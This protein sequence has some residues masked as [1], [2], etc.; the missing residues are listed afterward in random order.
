[1]LTL[2]TLLELLWYGS[3]TDEIVA[4]CGSDVEHVIVLRAGLIEKHSD[5]MYDM[6]VPNICRTGSHTARASMVPM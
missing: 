4:V 1:M 3:L 6:E 5:S 2:T